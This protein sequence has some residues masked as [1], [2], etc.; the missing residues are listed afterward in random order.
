MPSKF[1]PVK[2][3]VIPPAY[4]RASLA[5]DVTKSPAPVPPTPP[6]VSDWVKKANDR[7]SP[8]W[9]E[10]E[11]RGGRA[12]HMQGAT[13]AEAVEVAAIF[14]QTWDVGVTR[15]GCYVLIFKPKRDIPKQRR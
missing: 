13:F 3:P 4:E 2:P 10:N 1:D 5:P 15:D 11:V 8:M 12:F 7:L 14:K 6:D 9:Q